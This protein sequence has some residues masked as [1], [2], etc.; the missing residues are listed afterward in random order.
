MIAKFKFMYVFASSW[1]SLQ[2]ASISRCPPTSHLS[3]IQ[4]LQ[5]R[6]RDRI[7]TSIMLQRNTITSFLEI[8]SY[9]TGE[10][11]NLLIFFCR[12]LSRLFTLEWMFI[13]MLFFLF[14]LS[15]PYGRA[16]RRVVII[17]SSSRP[18][19]LIV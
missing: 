10:N 16:F 4:A 15:F 3:S 12:F 14:S 7:R 6:V 1:H 5:R 13:V 19:S 2:E 8:Q 17:P 9:E 18:R 11:E